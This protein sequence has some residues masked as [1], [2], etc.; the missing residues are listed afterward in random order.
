MSSE[1]RTTCLLAAS[2]L[3]SALPASLYASGNPDAH[4]HGHAVFQLAVSGDQVDLIFTSPAYNLLGFE[5]Q[6]RTEE[7]KARVKEIQAWLEDTPLADT[8]E[9]GC[10]LN[11]TD[12]H[13]EMGGED[14]E[15]HGD[16]EHDHAEERGSHSDIEITQ[17]LT[18]SG[19]EGSVEFTTFLTD[20]FPELEE[21]SVEWVW[22]GR[23]G[24]TRLR[25]GD[26]YFRLDAGQ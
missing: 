9:S 19:L 16:H 23:Q 21:L 4:Q 6:A 12:V 20:R 13:S 15:H 8:A 2:A 11:E 1:K 22:G 10:R 24:S 26:S 17:T 25:Q 3:L 18:C 14:G 7:Q 5:H